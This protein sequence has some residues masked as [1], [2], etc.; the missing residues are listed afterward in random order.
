M[1][2][3]TSIVYFGSHT[4]LIL[5]LLMMTQGAFVDSLD[6]DQTSQNVPSD[7]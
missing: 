4:P 7:L 1:Y 6:Q 3:N 2:I 5:S